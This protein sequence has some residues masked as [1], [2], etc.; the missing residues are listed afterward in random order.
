MRWAVWRQMCRR[1][2]ACARCGRQSGWVVD[3]VRVRCARCRRQEVW[4]KG[5]MRERSPEAEAVSGGVCAI[6]ATKGVGGRLV[7]VG[8]SEL[9]VAGY[10]VLF[11]RHFATSLPISCRHFLTPYL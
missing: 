11:G 10:L 8:C 1:R 6:H 2:C 4:A 5:D 9:A 7:V 3:R